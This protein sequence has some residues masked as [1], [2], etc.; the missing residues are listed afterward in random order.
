MIKKTACKNH[1]DTLTARKCYYCADSIC[2][3]CQK[4][5]ENH[6]FC[7]RKCFYKWKIVE[8]ISKFSISADTVI[9]FLLLAFLNI[10]TIFYLNTKNSD[11][12]DI[13]DVKDIKPVGEGIWKL[14][15]LRY[16]ISNSY[17]IR[18]N[19]GAGSL[20]GLWRDGKFVESRIQTDTSTFTFD[21][22]Y[23]K[24]GINRFA[25]WALTERGKR[26]LIDSFAVTFDSPRLNFLKN[27]VYEFRNSGKNIALTF[28]GGSLNSGTAEILTALKK[29]D[30]R[31]TLFLTGS[32]I[33]RY[34]ELVRKMIEDGHEIGNHSMTHPHLTMLEIDRSNHTRNGVTREFVQHQLLSVDSLFRTVTNHQMAP[35]WRAPFGEINEQVALWAAEIGFKHIGWSQNCDSRDWVADAGSSLYRTN[36][37]ILQ[38]FIEQEEQSGMSG[39]IILMHLGSERKDDFPYLILPDLIEQLKRRG[40]GFKTISQMFSNN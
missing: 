37:E 6:L 22:Q 24:T 14:D 16:G 38:H 31:C 1:P 39:K 7:G 3:A 19:G 10:F 12:P 28:D 15:T 13:S 18:I 32:F 23:L 17:Q 40:Y 2:S 4:H 29:A 27:P 9:L 34:P 33:R 36:T 8:F 35:F 11:S 5:F 30:V 20:I 21:K 25:I 26:V